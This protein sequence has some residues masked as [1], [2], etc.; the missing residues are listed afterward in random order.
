MAMPHRRW[1]CHDKMGRPT[2]KDGC[3]THRR[4][5]CHICTR[6]VR[7]CDAK[8]ESLPFVLGAPIELEC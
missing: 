5:L 2:P 1:Q 4:W 6:Q 3:A 8:S 7:H